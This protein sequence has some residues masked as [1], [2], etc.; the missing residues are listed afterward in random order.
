MFIMYYMTCMHNC[1]LTQ[2]FIVTIVY[3]ITKS[4]FL[5]YLLD[6][7][8]IVFSLFCVLSTDSYCYIIHWILDFKYKLFLFIALFMS[9]TA[10]SK[11]FT[12]KKYYKYYYVSLFKIHLKMVIFSLYLFNIRNKFISF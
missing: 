6:N 10:I 3:N 1:H 9:L 4:M 11:Y 7:C 12:N 2:I 8:H 5:P